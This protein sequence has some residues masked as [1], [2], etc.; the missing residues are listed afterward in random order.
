MT[1]KTWKRYLSLLLTIVLVLALLPAMELPAWAAEVDTG[2]AGLTAESGGN[3]SWNYTNGSITGSVA[4]SESSSCFGTSYSSQ[5]A[6]LTL[7]N[8]SGAVA[9]LS[10]D[11][12]DVVSNVKIDEKTVTAGSTFSKKLED[13]GSIKIEITSGD[14]EGANAAIS[15]SNIKLT[16]EKEITLT[17]NAPSNGSYSVAGTAV[18]AV[19]SKIVLSTDMVALSASAASNYKFLGWFNVDTDACLSTSASVSL[20]FSENMTLEPRFVSSTL[21]LFLV[22]NRIYTDLNDATAYAT[23]SGTKKITLI[24]DGT[25]AAG[26]YAIPNGVTLLVPYDAGY[27]MVKDAPEVIAS[28]TNPSKYMLLTM[29]NGASITVQNGGAISV[30]SLLCSKDQLGGWN[31]CPTGPDGRI[32]MNEGSSITV[33]NG[34]TLYCWGY[35]YGSGSVEAQDGST[36]YEAF[37][38]KD[39]RGG[40]RTLTISSSIFIFNQYYIQNIEVPLKI[41]AGA[42]EILR[43][44]ANG[45][46]SVQPMNVTFIGSNT[47]MFHVTSGYLIKDYI[48]NTDRLQID[49]YGDTSIS[50]MTISGLPLVNSISTN[51]YVLPITSNITINMHSGTTT[52]DQSIELLPSVEININSG[53]VLS[54]SSDKNVYVYDVDNWDNFTGDAKL[55]VIGYSVANGTTTKRT[56]ASLTDAIIKVNGVVNVSGKLYTSQGGANITSDGNG[57]IVF[58]KAQATKDTTIKEDKNNNTLTDVTFNPARLHNGTSDPTYTATSGAAANTTFTYCSTHNRWERASAQVNYN[59][60]GGTGTMQ[61]QTLSRDTGTVAANGFTRTGFAF[62][63][64]NTASDGSGTAYAPG[65]PAHF[66]S[67]PVTLYAQWEA[68]SFTVTWKNE[69]EATWGLPPLRRATD[70]PTAELLLNLRQCSKSG[71]LTLLQAGRKTTAVRSMPMITCL[72]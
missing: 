68:G 67:S 1:H 34:G 70:R 51:N 54:I 5:S 60:N 17:L 23:S 43:S 50:P 19:T 31:G 48:E 18:T 56:A 21:P 47:G 61:V 12:S 7:T 55:R 36:I 35:I 40:N 9:M 65:D 38:I 11:Y 28:H 27:T 8:S 29:A 30:A 14:S 46:G 64:W 26:S 2:V 44:A 24:S 42:T 16:E 39:W 69:N 71:I 66:T 57:Q 37:Q 72:R 15:I 45:A 53:A 4:P 22:G 59:A 63:G 58:V 32:K 33:Q 52:V 25:L 20:S 6:S 62:T 3:G 13:G 49:V 41:H 10:F